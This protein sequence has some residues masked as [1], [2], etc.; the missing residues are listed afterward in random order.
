VLVFGEIFNCSVTFRRQALTVGLD[1]LEIAGAWDGSAVI[2]PHC[3]RSR[4]F[5]SR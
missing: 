2:G 1:T 5:Y 3:F 4:D